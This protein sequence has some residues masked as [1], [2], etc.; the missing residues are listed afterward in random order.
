MYYKHFTALGILVALGG[1]EGE[2]IRGKEMLSVSVLSD[3]A[4]KTLKSGG[5]IEVYGVKNACNLP[6]RKSC[7]FLSE[8]HFASGD[9][10]LLCEQGPLK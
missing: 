5:S 1:G 7:T 3:V 2:E 4:G 10:M 6:K 8:R 9:R